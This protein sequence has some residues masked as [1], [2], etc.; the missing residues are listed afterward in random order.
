[1]ENLILSNV[2]IRGDSNCDDKS[3][4]KVFKWSELHSERNYFLQN[5]N[6]SKVGLLEEMLPYNSQH[7]SKFEFP[8]CK[9]LAQL[10]PSDSKTEKDSS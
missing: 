2:L 7:T 1:M 5:Y 10:T 3:G 6:F 9:T 4:Q 8:H